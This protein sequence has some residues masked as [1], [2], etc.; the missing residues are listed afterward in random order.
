MGATER[1]FES[2]AIASAMN[3][4]R[5][6]GQP[7]LTNRGHLNPVLV[8]RV[9]AAIIDLLAEIFRRL[10]G[11]E[12]ALASKRPGAD[13]LPDFVHH[14]R[15][16]IIEIDET[17]HFTTDRL[18]TF[19]AYPRGASLAYDVVIYQELVR[20]WCS[21]GDRY[22]ASKQTVDFSFTGGRRAQRAYFDTVRDLLAP[23]FGWRVIRVPAPECDPVLAFDRFRG[24]IEP[25][26]RS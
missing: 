12:A 11:D 6:F 10:G 16:L 21:H 3:L 18:A 15:R 2:L 4:E 25:N 26:S 5:A 14:E 7:W 1:G 8:R 13:P 9:P 22:R 17:Q 24:L 20:T 19:D 23:C